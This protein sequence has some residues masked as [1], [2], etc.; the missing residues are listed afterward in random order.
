MAVTEER[1]RIKLVDQ[2]SGGLNTATT[3]MN[4]FNKNTLRKEDYNEHFINSS[5]R[6]SQT[7]FTL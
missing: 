2:F 5:Y 6:V 4:S 7:T 3:R 1:V